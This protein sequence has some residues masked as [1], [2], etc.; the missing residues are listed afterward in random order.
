MRTRR[1]GAIGCLLRANRGAEH[2]RGA[3]TRGLRADRER[4]EPA[5]Q[6][7]G[8]PNLT[9][10][11]WRAAPGWSAGL[12]AWRRVARQT[13]G[14]RWGTAAPPERAALEPTAPGATRPG[15][16][17]WWRRSIPGVIDPR[18]DCDEAAST[19][20]PWSGAGSVRPRSSEARPPAHTRERITDGVPGRQGR[21]AGRPPGPT[22]G[23]PETRGT[24][25]SERCGEEPV[26]GVLSFGEGQRSGL[27]ARP[28]DAHQ[29]RVRRWMGSAV[30]L[31]P[32]HHPDPHSMG[33]RSRTRAAMQTPWS[34]AP[35]NT[36]PSGAPPAEP[37]RTHQGRV[38]ED[39]G[40]G[41]GR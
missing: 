37:T 23:S 15:S 5:K 29:V 33:L 30:K 39:A 8:A 22:A 35:G 10:G 26:A 31:D 36:H 20:H 21:Q 3:W 34:L 7:R 6:Q 2:W 18:V 9:G 25:C 32:F 28:G 41:L 16:E 38:A 17:R 11:S 40:A 14:A 27:R 4:C 24:P 19:S 13:R 1:G 12:R